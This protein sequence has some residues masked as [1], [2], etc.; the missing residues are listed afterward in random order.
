MLR[1]SKENPPWG[2]GKLQGELLKL[3]YEIGRS[4]VR[5]ILQRRHVPPAPERAKQGSSWRTF[6]TH[7][8]QQLLAC[9]FFIV[10]TAWLQTFYLFFFSEIG[11]QR[12]HFAGC[13]A[14][15]TAEWVTQQARQLTWML[16][17]GQLPI[18]FLIQDRDAKFLT[19]CER[20]FVAEGIAILR[21]PYQAPIATA[22]AA[23]WV[24]A[25]RAEALDKLLIR[26]HAHWQRVLTEYV[27]YFNPNTSGVAKFWITNSGQTLNVHWFGACGGGL[28]DNGAKSQAYNGEPFTILFNPVRCGNCI[29]SSNALHKRVS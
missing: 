3:G 13:T 19:S 5:D 20:V 8:S 25:V 27:G 15:P 10:E 9:D 16:Q 23:R 1:L 4:T 26:H 6:L 24:S 12:V 17:D 18:R 22:L 21:T 28:C 29:R 14:H 7:H 11:S 2:Y